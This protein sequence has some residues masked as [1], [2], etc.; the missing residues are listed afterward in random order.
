MSVR[1]GVATVTKPDPATPSTTGAIHR[2]QRPRIDVHELRMACMKIARR[3]RAES[4]GSLTPGQFGVLANLANHG[5]RTPGELAA[6]EYVQAPSMT[7]TIAMLVERGLVERGPHATDR[8][9]VM[10]TITEK[11]RAELKVSRRT[12][13]EWVTA[14]LGSLTDDERLVLAKATP[15]L[16]RLANS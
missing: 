11:G 2:Q 13:D 16:E 15:I 3:V 10:L 12:R 14:R 4:S 5:A 7:R 1:P 6:D 9:Q 8:R